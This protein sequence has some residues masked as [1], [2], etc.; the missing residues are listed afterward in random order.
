MK[1]VFAESAIRRAAC[2][3]LV[4]I[5]SP[6]GAAPLFVQRLNAGTNVIENGAYG[7]GGAAT[8]DVRLVIGEPGGL[9]GGSP[10]VQGGA[11]EVW[12]VDNGAF[13]REQRLLPPAPVAGGFFGA[14]VAL[15]G[16]WL[17]LLD[18]SDGSN[19]IRI[20]HFAGGNW[21]PTQVIDEPP[22]DTSSFGVALALHGDLLA[23]GASGY[24]TPGSGVAGSGAVYVYRLQSDTWQAAATIEGTDPLAQR[25]LGSA[26]ALSVGA[27]GVTRLAAGASGRSSGAGAVYVFRDEIPT[28]VQEQRLQLSNAQN[29]E[30]LG[31]SVALRGATLVAGAPQ[32]TVGAQA[33]AG[34]VAVWRRKA[35]GD[36]PWVLEATTGEPAPAAD[37]RFGSAVALPREDE[38]VAGAPFR[39]VVVVGTVAN[40]GVVR[41]LRRS[42]AP[43]TCAAGWSDVGQVGNPNV[44]AQTNA[45]Y[46]GLLGAGARYSAVVAIGATVQSVPAAG[47][48]DA[49]LQDRLFDDA[50]DCPP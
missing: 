31:A 4:A 35:S 21:V 39:D 22:E 5:A 1:T 50:F 25:Q 28:W 12:R 23:I 20:H 16:D 3:S 11:V 38:A 45:L 32:A 6:T 49:M 33:S 40:A 18:P 19:R 24:S 44:L 8:D 27:D 2:A 7:Y 46:G 30:H 9:S 34:R 10:A 13:V 36:F 42:L 41:L 17:A 48:V 47:A 29:D 37:D 43:S 26:V 15:D 14:R